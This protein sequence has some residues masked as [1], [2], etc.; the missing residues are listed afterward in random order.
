MRRSIIAFFALVLTAC[1]GRSASIASPAS[2]GPSSASRSSAAGEGAQSESRGD[3]AA[4]SAAPAPAYGPAPATQAAPEYGAPGGMQAPK[5]ADAAGSRGA[6]PTERPGLGTE[7][8]ETRSSR[9]H[10]VSFVRSDATN[11]MAMLSV[12]Y[13]D[14]TSI[15]A[16]ARYHNDRSS[17]ARRF[18][19]AN[20]YVSVAIEGGNGDPLETVRVGGRSYVVGEEGSRYVLAITNHSG[21][22]FE[23]VATVDGLDVLTGR[24]GSA[25]RRG[26][27]VMPHGTLR[28]DGFR[29]SEDAVAAFRFS[30]VAESYAARTGSDRN[31]GVIGF[32]FFSE[33]GVVL[34]PWNE[35]EIRRR[36]TASPFP[37]D[38]RYARPPNRN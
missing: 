22:R 14:R 32:A 6:R 37:Q 28:I 5:S 17:E 9:V 23:V 19:T 25:A 12:N 15:D 27:L 4:K 20:G 18:V 3:S 34:E 26:Y 1:G 29:Q 8:G 16:L 38:T 35:E 21:Y 33:R 10:E 13:N 36:E 2:E 7:W 30:R 11:P 31:V 24:A